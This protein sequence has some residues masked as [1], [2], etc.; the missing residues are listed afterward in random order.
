MIDD[1]YTSWT[2]HEFA[3]LRDL[4]ASRITLFNARRSGEPSP[5]THCV[6]GYM[7]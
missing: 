6:G 3:E 4:A 5:K 1:P 7:Q 2:G